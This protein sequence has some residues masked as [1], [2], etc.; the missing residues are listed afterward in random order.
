[1]NDIAEN[2]V[3]DRQI[4]RTTAVTLGCNVPT[5]TYRYVRKLMLRACTNTSLLRQGK[6]GRGDEACKESSQLVHAP[7]ALAG[8]PTS[9]SPTQDMRRGV[10]VHPTIFFTGILCHN[11]GR[12]KLS[13]GKF[14]A[15]IVSFV[16]RQ[17]S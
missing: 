12:A 1:M 6:N 16:S 3:T 2:A 11:I 5:V 8:C 10:S 15:R 7:Y 9:K 4:H 13:E 14:Y 17:F